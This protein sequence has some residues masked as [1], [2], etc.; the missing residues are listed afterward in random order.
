MKTKFSLTLLLFLAI[1]QVSCQ[2]TNPEKS[3]INND[4]T[5]VEVV[6]ADGF[7]RAYFAIHFFSFNDN[8]RIIC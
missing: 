5:P 6:S 8:F 1:L 3:N 4:L 2:Q 7:K